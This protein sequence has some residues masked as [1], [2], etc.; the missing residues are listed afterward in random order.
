MEDVG[1]EVL[2]STFAAI[3]SLGV[4]GTL[5]AVLTHWRLGPALDGT[6]PTVDLH[7]LGID[8]G[9]ADT[10]DTGGA[11]EGDEEETVSLSRG[12]VSRLRRRRD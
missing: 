6:E 12:L 2:A 9:R 10:G 8:A 11:A 5:G 7:T 1:P 4:G 3:V